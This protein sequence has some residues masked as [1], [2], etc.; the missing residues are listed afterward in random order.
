[1]EEV[2]NMKKRITGAAAVAR[3]LE[4]RNRINARLLTA[5]GE[6]VRAVLPDYAGR[7][8]KAE[9]LEKMRAE[10]GENR[11]SRRGGDSFPSV[12]SGLF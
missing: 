3:E 10:F 5:A 4:K 2:W 8:L 1:M 7:G 12:S 6:G 11:I 9:Q